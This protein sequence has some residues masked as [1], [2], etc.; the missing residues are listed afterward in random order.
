[1]L[2]SWFSVP[3]GN[4]SIGLDYFKKIQKKKTKNVFDLDL[5]Y[6]INERN[7][8]NSVPYRYRLWMNCSAVLLAWVLICICQIVVT[9]WR[10]CSAVSQYFL[11]SC[12]VWF[13]KTCLWRSGIFLLFSFGVFFLAFKWFSILKSVSSRGPRTKVSL[14]LLLFLYYSS[15]FPSAFASLDL[16]WCC[17]CFWNVC[18]NACTIWKG[19]GMREEWKAVWAV[20]D[21]TSLA[22]VMFC[23]FAG[24]SFNQI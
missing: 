20:R 15:N 12:A 9:A 5:W 7:G 1:M 8:S 14:S 21:L 13:L 11:R 22:S 10:H 17:R 4:Y 3:H 18:G 23:I 19:E 6:I 2:F 24:I 16:T